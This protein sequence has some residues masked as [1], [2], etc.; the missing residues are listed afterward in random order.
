MIKE[1][2][3]QRFGIYDLDVPDTIN[4]D[5]INLAY[6]INSES[7]HINPV[8]DP[9]T[10]PSETIYT[11]NTNSYVGA[12]MGLLNRM[13]LYSSFPSEFISSFINPVIES[14]IEATNY[15]DCGIPDL[16]PYVERC[17]F[18]LIVKD[19]SIDIH[20][21]DKAGSLAIAYYPDDMI[22]K[23]NFLVFSHGL[24]ADIFS[25]EVNPRHELIETKKSRLIIFPSHMYHC[26]ECNLSDQ[27]RISYSMDVNFIGTETF[28]PPVELIETVHKSFKQRLNFIGEA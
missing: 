3:G 26:T 14:Y 7:M 18:T 2:F 27:T 15:V 25:K 8:V 28:M 21:H 11:S 16:M 10:H 12:H 13:H 20:N 24:D 4:E 9:G 5:L 19:D 22:D 23:G 6:H 17:W 1:I